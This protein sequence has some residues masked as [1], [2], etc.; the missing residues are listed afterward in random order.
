MSVNDPHIIRTTEVRH[1]YG[2]GPDPAVVTSEVRES[3]AGWW[4]GALVA[5][6]AILAVVFLVTREPSAS[7]D[8][9]IARAIDASRTEAALAN[10]QMSA[11]QATLSAQDAAIRAA[12]DAA[13]RSANS[14]IMAANDATAR[15]EAA[16]RS[17]QAAAA[18]ANSAPP[19]VIVSPP[20]EPTVTIQ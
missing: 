17:A 6:V 10:A 18:N 5:I 20:V 3:S 12:Q 9:E 2:S 15:A 19:T 4:L 7:P 1:T 16:A 8:A 14:A 11:S 13:N